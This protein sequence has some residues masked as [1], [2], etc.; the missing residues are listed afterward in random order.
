MSLLIVY[1]IYWNFI[2]TVHNLELIDPD[3]RRSNLFI[4]ILKKNEVF[5]IDEEY[6]IFY[7]LDPTNIF[8]DKRHVEHKSKR[9]S[10]HFDNF[11]ED[12]FAFLFH[13]MYEKNSKFFFINTHHI[14]NVFYY[15]YKF[16]R[17][18]TIKRNF[19]KRFYYHNILTFNFLKKKLNI[20]YSCKNNL[21][22]SITP[23]II[24]KKLDIINKK[25]KKSIKIVNIMVKSMLKTYRK[26]ENYHKLIIQVKGTK[27]SFYKILIFVKD[28]LKKYTD[29]YFIYTPVISFS[30]KNFKKI[31]SLKR[32]FR[33]KYFKN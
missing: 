14:L 18:Y 29:A 28:I 24:T 16:N 4:K 31:R 8:N 32:N 6:V 2:Y 23:G 22:S 5:F 17:K 21:I 30:K 33:K 27:S 3:R 10:K 20:T 12:L 1:L 7:E 11:I 13:L 19:F 25:N 9:W 15:I 26:N